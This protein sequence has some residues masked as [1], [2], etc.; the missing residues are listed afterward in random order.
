MADAPAP[1]SGPPFEVVL[2]P[3]TQRIY[4]DGMAQLHMGVPSSAVYFNEMSLPAEPG[5]TEQRRVNLVL[6]I[7]TV[8]LLE[9]AR[10]V[11]ASANDIAQPLMVASA[12]QNKRLAD[13]LDTIRDPET[14]K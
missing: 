12:E 2:G 7:P 4:C 11:L 3:D 14:K 13:L 1:Q 5:K 9:I 8:S 6:Q 10:I